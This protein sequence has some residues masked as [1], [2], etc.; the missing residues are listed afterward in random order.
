MIKKP[1]YILIIFIISVLI[2]GIVFS[3]ITLGD[4]KS[5]DVAEA[6]RNTII[7]SLGIDYGKSATQSSYVTLNLNVTGQDVNLSTLKTQFSLDNKNW[8]GFN[9]VANKWEN[10]YLGKYESFYSGFYIG[11]VS[12]SKTVYVKVI[13]DNGNVGS[14]SAKI[15]YSPYTQNPEI[16]TP[17]SSELNIL[18]SASGKA[19]IKSGSGT[20][21]DPY[22]VSGNNTRLV[23]KMPNVAEVSYY[24]DGSTWSSWYKVTGGQADIPVTFN[25]VEGLKEV[26]LRSKNQHGVEGD[27]EI[28]YYLLDYTSPTVKLHTDFHSFIAVEGKLQFDL[29]VDDNLSK[30]LDFEIE[31][32]ADGNSVVK[33][34]K[35][36][37]YDENK[38]TTTS[39]TID[40]LSPGRFNLKATV[41]D[42]AGNRGIKQVSVDSL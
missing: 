12:G 10:G 18:Q 34:G 5:D 2:F 11:S 41:T 19:G 36:E 14:A 15:N 27:A 16:V 4:T 37:K 30:F 9:S 31:I 8:S 7:V 6:P 28:I 40:G 21:Y 29:E 26:R 35:I 13:D 39:I 33:Q 20:L 17:A 25:N 23:S 32:S 1:Y 3:N 24:T 22:I 38:P 42:A